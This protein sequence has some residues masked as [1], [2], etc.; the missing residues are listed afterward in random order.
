MLG[1][2]QSMCLCTRNPPIRR[3]S[4]GRRPLTL[5][6]LPLEST[7]HPRHRGHPDRRARAQSRSFD[8]NRGWSRRVCRYPLTLLSRY[9][10]VVFGNSDVDLSL[11]FCSMEE[12]MRQEARRVPTT[13]L[14]ATERR[15]R[16]STVN[17]P[18]NLATSFM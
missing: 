18:P 12:I 17:S 4:C 16:S 15:F 5:R 9:Q 2:C 3:T 6:T 13:F 7:T 14:Y 1:Q 11:P 8:G 10:Y